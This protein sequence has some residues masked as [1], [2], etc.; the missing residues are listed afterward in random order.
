MDSTERK[1]IVE[2]NLRL[3]MIHDAMAKQMMTNNHVAERTATTSK[4]KTDLE[5]GESDLQ[6]EDKHPRTFS[7]LEAILKCQGLQ[8]K[9]ILNLE[10][11]V[12]ASET[13]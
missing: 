7:L 5:R 9:P 6:N 11:E 1:R 13:S 8:V 10:N 4:M 12:K 3:F 2:H